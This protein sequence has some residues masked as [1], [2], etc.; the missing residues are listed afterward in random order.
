VNG[1]NEE[2]IDLPGGR[3][4]LLRSGTRGRLLILLHGFPDHPPSFRRLIPLL[5]RGGYDVVAPWLRGYEPSTLAGPYDLERIA[6][7][8]LELASSLGHERFTLVGH[9]WGATAT[10]VACSLAPERVAAAVALSIPHPRTFRK[11]EQ[12]PLSAYMPVLAAPGGAQLAR[13]FDFRFV[14]LLWRRWS[15]N[16]ALEAEDRRALHACLRASWP[17]PARYYRALFWPPGESAAILNRVRVRVPLLHLH[18]RGDGCVAASTGAGQAR[19]FA[20]PFRTELHPSAG[21]FLTLE[22]PEWVAD[23]TLAW[24][25]KYFDHR[26]LAPAL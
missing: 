26:S 24:L 10:Y 5:A 21:H 8:A 15:P 17:A 3:F 2:R 18:G 22:A 1:V 16:F 11:P 7:D 23:H 13:A 19:Y 12:L 25:D 6:R 14:D 20:G 9:D 4:S